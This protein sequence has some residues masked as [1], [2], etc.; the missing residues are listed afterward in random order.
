MPFPYFYAAE[1]IDKRPAHDR[2]DT[3]DQ[4]KNHYVPKIPQQCQKEQNTKKD[5]DVP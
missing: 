3:R 1:Q 2:K 5:Q 4:Y